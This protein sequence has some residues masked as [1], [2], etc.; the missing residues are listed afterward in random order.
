MDVGFPERLCPA[1]QIRPQPTHPVRQY[2]AWHREVC[3]D[4]AVVP[5]VYNPALQQPAVVCPQILE[6]VVKS[7]N[8][9]GSHRGDLG[10]VTGS[11]VA[12]LIDGYR[13]AVAPGVPCTSLPVMSRPALEVPGARSKPKGTPRKYQDGVFPCPATAAGEDGDSLDSC[14]TGVGIMVA[15]SRRGPAVP[16]ASE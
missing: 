5:A 15:R 4:V 8:S 2:T 10:H 13:A 7:V 9:R 16:A 14:P 12:H 6:E 3:G 1:P 11:S